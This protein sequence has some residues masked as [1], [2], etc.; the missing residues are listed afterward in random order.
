MNGVCHCLDWGIEP[1]VP[2]RANRDRLVSNARIRRQEPHLPLNGISQGL[3]AKAG[4]L[5]PALKNFF[6]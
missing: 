6:L 2:Q 5:L 3:P 4:I 1:S